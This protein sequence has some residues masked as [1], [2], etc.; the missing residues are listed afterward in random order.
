MQV[1]H[2]AQHQP[3]VLLLAR[4]QVT[5]Q[6]WLQL[7]QQQALVMQQTQF[8]QLQKAQVMQQPQLQQQQ[9]ALVKQQPQL[10]LPYCLPLA[11]EKDWA[12]RL[13]Q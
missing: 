13:E 5:Q 4:A 12:L 11:L 8:Q 3:K 7:Q 9:Q 1:K 10:R 2:S 6:I